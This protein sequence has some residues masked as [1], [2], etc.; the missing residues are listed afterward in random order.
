MDVFETL[1]QRLLCRVFGHRWHF[2]HA[3]DAGGKV[4]ACHRCRR[5]A[6]F[7]R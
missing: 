4:Y 7:I 6:T 3:R 5:E 1:C 2:L